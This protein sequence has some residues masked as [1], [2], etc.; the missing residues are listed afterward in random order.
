MSPDYTNRKTDENRFDSRKLKSE[1]VYAYY[2]LSHQ[3]IYDAVLAIETAR[4]AL[5]HDALLHELLVEWLPLLTTRGAHLQA[6]SQGTFELGQRIS[7]HRRIEQSLNALAGDKRPADAPGRM[8][9]L[10]GRRLDAMRFAAQIHSV[11]REA[12]RA[13]VW[14]QNWQD[15]YT[16]LPQHERAARGLLDPQ[17]VLEGV[18][19]AN[20]VHSHLQDQQ[21]RADVSDRMSRVA[22]RLRLVFRYKACV[23]T[24]LTRMYNRPTAADLQQALAQADDFSKWLGRLVEVNVNLRTQDLQFVLQNYMFNARL[25]LAKL[26]ASR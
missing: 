18:L 17:A 9:R 4:D 3:K 20:L 14:Q 6:Y 25:R 13:K 12:T 16:E 19:A 10:F 26:I 7:N 1:A 8:T 2:S 23:Q 11:D 24:L 22:A 21:A 5:P 15:V